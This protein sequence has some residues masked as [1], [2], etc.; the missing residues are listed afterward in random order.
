MLDPTVL[1]S[2]FEDGRNFVVVFGGGWDERRDFSSR[3]EAWAST[4]ALGL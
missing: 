3:D 1:M 4:N 2:W